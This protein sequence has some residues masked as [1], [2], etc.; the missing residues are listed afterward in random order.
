MDTI[1]VKV[2][3]SG[4]VKVNSEFEAEAPLEMVWFPGNDLIIETKYERIV[5]NSDVDV[6][7]QPKVAE[8]T[9]TLIKDANIKLMQNNVARYL[10]LD[11][12]WAF[13]LPLTNA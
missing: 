5:V 8:K 11:D 10:I 12:K 6:V 4:V 1:A 2:N 9:L 13:R 7:V 3:Y